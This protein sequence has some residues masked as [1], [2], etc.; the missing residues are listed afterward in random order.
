M[1]TIVTPA[2]NAAATV[3][4][5]LASVASQ[6]VPAEHLIIDGASTDGTVETVHRLS[7]LLS[8]GPRVISEPDCGI[9]DAM[10]K[11]IG[12]A[13]GEII[14]ILNADDFYADDRVL[15]RVSAVFEDPEVDACYGDLVYIRPG[16]CCREQ[17]QQAPQD[18]CIVRYWR[19]GE[20]SQRK[21]YQGWMPPHPTFFVRR[22]IYAQFGTF[23]PSLGTAADYELMLR[24]L[25]RH[26]IR[27][28]YIPEVLVVMRSGGASNATW[29][30]RLEANRM[31]RKAW[32]V[33]GLT[34]RPWTIPLKP[35]RK[36]FQFL[37]R[38]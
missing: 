12:L 20:G 2:F 21:L 33:N 7:P 4:D 29:R 16:I 26:G 13:S 35:L 1:I 11:G 25:L 38:P 27:A 3:G 6:T 30:N 32:E 17:W 24:F 9:Y 34:P 10:N 23:N 5:T 37:D 14:G 36:L 19:T 31:D 8:A 18:S 28:C 22:R 15:E